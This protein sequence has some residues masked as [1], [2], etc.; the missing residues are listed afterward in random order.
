MQRRYGW[1]KQKDDPRDRRVLRTFGLV[2]EN[3]PSSYRIQNGMPPVWDQGETNSCSA[4]ASGAAYEYMLSKEKLPD[5]MPSRMFA[6]YN[7]RL[8]EGTEDTDGGA[9]IRDAVK[10]LVK[11]GTLPES[12]WPFSRP[13]NV[14]PPSDI[15]SR[16]LTGIVTSYAALDQDLESLKRSIANDQPVIFGFMVPQSFESNE[17]A[18]TGVLVI[19]GPNESIVG[20]HAVLATGYDDARKMFWIRNSW[21]PDW[22]QEGSFEMPYAFITDPKWASDFW[23]IQ[24]EN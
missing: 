3:L 19:P 11:Y 22:G 14:K 18:R 1:I 24:H 9:T 17:M 10:A 21:G 6:Y 16:A 13:Y 23:I 20:G 8:L 4:H 5:F 15:Y 7:S 2:S 12:L